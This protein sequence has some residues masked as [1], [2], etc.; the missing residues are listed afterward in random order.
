MREHDCVIS[1]QGAIQNV[2]REKQLRLIELIK[3]RL[4]EPIIRK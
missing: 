2:S 4:R 3:P 1:T